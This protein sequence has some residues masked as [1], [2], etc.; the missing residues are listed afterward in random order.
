[1][2][3]RHCFIPRSPVLAF[4]L[5]VCARAVTPLPAPEKFP[6][7]PP[8][9]ALLDDVFVRMKPYT[10]PTAA[11]LDRDGLRG[12]IFTGYQGWFHPDGDGSERPW[13]HYGASVDGKMI[14]RPGA[15]VI[16]L[17]P[18]M[19]EADADERFATEFKM[20]DGT[21]APVFSS[22]HPKTVFRHFRWMHDYSID[23]AFVQRFGTDLRR[24]QSYDV[25]NRVLENCRAGAHMNG[26]AW[27]VMYD[28]TG[29][30]R[31]EIRSLVMEDWKRLCAR[32][33]VQKDAAYLRHEG[34]PVV[35]VWGV[36]FSDA[37]DYT[38]DECRE[39]IRFLHDDPECGG[40]AIML[41]VP[42]WWRDGREDAVPAAQLH[43]LILEA[44][45]ISPWTVG[46]MGLLPMVATIAEQVWQEDIAWLAPHRKEYLPVAFPGFRWNNLAGTDKTAGLPGTRPHLDIPRLRGEFFWRQI[47]AAKQA[48]ASS[49][50]LAMFDE[51][52][53]GTAIFKA[54]N[55]PPMGASSFLDLDGLPADT[56]LWLAGQG[57]RMLRGELPLTLQPPLRKP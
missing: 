1:M 39:L 3:S 17:W 26:V 13:K 11:G 38:L 23:G 57:R 29:L 40:N 32:M 46:R 21:M 55:R 6:A 15:C 37:R 18:D 42:T 52:D 8:P 20:A 12:K 19:S 2:P 10:G 48:G 5:A 56:W 34:K 41:G 27:A 28:L 30:K 45:I 31:V 9:A 50:Y 53:E 24:P 16:D 36:G 43:P 33:A 22:W 47:A 7:H 14:F 4:A 49:L 54:A 51:M 25:R 35:A 44:D